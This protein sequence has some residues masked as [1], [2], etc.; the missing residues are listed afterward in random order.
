MKVRVLALLVSAL[1]FAQPGIA[2]PISTCANVGLPVGGI[3]DIQCTVFSNGSPNTFNLQPL[4]TQAGALLSDNDYQAAYFPV[5]N[6]DPTTLP[7]TS[8]GLLNQNL[9]QAVLFF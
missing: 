7:D 5:I 6:G 2:L 3:V 1:A 8:S 9:W 4:M